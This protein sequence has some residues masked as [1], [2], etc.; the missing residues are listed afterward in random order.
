MQ[1][2]F[3][4]YRKTGLLNLLGIVKLGVNTL[5]KDVKSGA[6]HYWV[7]TKKFAKGTKV[8]SSC[9]CKCLPRCNLLEGGVTQGV[10][11]GDARMWQP[12]TDSLLFLQV[13]YQVVAYNFNARSTASK[14]LCITK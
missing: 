12:V 8:C 10:R 11:T 2:G 3:L 13:C 6:V 9:E 4:V 7:D 5:A 14:E 1:D